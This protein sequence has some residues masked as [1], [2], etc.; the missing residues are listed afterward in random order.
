MD[1]HTVLNR[2][3]IKSFYSFELPS[4]K[5]NGSGM[6]QALCPFH[7]D[8]KPSLSI[9]VNT[10]QFKCFGCSKTGSIFDFY[11]TKHNVDFRTAK[12]ALAREAGVTAEKKIVTTYD[13]KDESENLLFQTVR[14]EPKDF[15]QRRPDGKEN[16]L[17]NLQGILLVPYNLSEVIKAKSVIIVEGEKDV[18]T[19]KRINLIACCNP[20]GAGKW[21]AEY[22]HY[23]K[24]KKI[25]IFPDND[26]P[27]KRHAET[28]SKNLKGIAESIKV[29]ELPGLP[30]KG[31]ISDWLNHG[32][33]KDELLKVIKSSPEWIEPKS[34]P[35]SFLKKGADLL[36]LECSIEWVIDKLIPKQSITLLHGKG[37][38]G[39]T[40]LSLIIADAVSK[41]ISFLA[42]TTQQLPVI[43]IDFENS[44]PVLVDRVKKIQ[45]SEVLFWH[46][47]N[48][49]KPP[50]LD[51]LSWEQ[52]KSL[53]IGLLIFDTLRA[54]QGQDEN[55]SK[56]MAFIMG[57]L[58]ELRD[59]GFSIILLHHTPKSNDRTYKGSTA[60]MDLADHVLSLHKVRKRNLQDVADDEDEEDCFYKLGTRDKTRYEP[61]HI[62]LDFDP[63]KGFVI[64][65]DPN[66][67]DLKE[68]HSIITDL[69]KSTGEPPIQSKIIDQAKEELELSKSKTTRL[70]R[71]G[72]GKYWQ[73]QKLPERKNAK[74]Y[75]PISVYQFSNWI[76]R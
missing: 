14:Y 21:K 55:D 51:H 57:R 29:I 69:R 33:T 76:F 52:Y 72:E 56:N 46:N 61:F 15:K 54:S 44:L 18:E 31:D 28:I 32:H 10:G 53:P 17:Y 42:L 34:E 65:P 64:A 60:I 45:A 8:T 2:L 74:V 59:M 38:I 11:M 7:E 3:D 73:S 4:I 16:W 36:T 30:A 67:E 49:L 70:L 20:M 6:G 62:F 48:E 39:K 71:K 23:F 66:E 43:Y 5:W 25:A 37:G 1:K 41:G 12:D 19:L 22:N 50:K 9:N 68:L 26:E 24:G 35:L 75:D 13:Y 27:G 58:K 40:W 63:E 47:T